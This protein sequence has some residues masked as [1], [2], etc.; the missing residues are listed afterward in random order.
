[1]RTGAIS[2]ASV[3]STSACSE[4]AQRWRTGVGKGSISILTAQANGNTKENIASSRTSLSCSV[5]RKLEE[6]YR[7]I[8]Q[9][10]LTLEF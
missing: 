2:L 1:M 5:Y 9:L 10:H 8:L 3:G 4:K 7:V 6:S